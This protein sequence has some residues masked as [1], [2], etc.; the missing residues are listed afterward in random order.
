MIGTRN[1][2]RPFREAIGNALR[3]PSNGLHAMSDSLLFKKFLVP[4]SFRFTQSFPTLWL[5][6]PEHITPQATFLLRVQLS[7][8]SHSLKGLFSES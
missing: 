6:K 2:E 7:L 4:P 5:I 3:Q 8:D 1:G